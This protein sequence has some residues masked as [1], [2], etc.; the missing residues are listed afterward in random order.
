[1]VRAAVSES[2]SNAAT[3]LLSSCLDLSVNGHLV[4]CE[5]RFTMS[6]NVFGRTRG[7]PAIPCRSASEMTRIANRRSRSIERHLLKERFHRR[8]HS[9]SAPLSSLFILGYS[10]TIMSFCV[11]CTQK[12]TWEG[13]PTGKVCIHLALTRSCLT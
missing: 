7:A 3:L 1:M 13:E 2:Q 4:C 9:I 11:H 6:A 10:S 12:V 5:K 8:P